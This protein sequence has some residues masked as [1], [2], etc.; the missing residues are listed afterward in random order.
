MTSR[1]SAVGPLGAAFFEPYD[2]WPDAGT[3]Y[4]GLPATS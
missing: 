2:Y 3:P 4:H 1:L